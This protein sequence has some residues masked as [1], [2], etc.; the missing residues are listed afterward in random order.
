MVLV[1]NRGPVVLVDF[2]I[3]LIEAFGGQSFGER[4][5]APVR[6]GDSGLVRLRKVRIRMIS[7]SA[8]TT[9]PSQL[10]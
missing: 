8:K 3:I 1:Y 5:P 10:Y 6:R 9:G 7:K 4:E 2:E